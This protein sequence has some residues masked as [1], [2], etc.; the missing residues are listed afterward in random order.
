MKIVLDMQGAQ[1]QSRHRG[2]GRYSLELA[3]AFAALAGQRHDLQFAFNAQLDEAT[4]ALIAALQPQADRSHRLMIKSLP[5]VAAQGAENTARRQAAEQVMRLALDQQHADVVWYSSMIEGYVDDAVI[6]ELPV[7]RG[8]S[9][10]TLYDLIPLHDPDAY[11]GHP[12]VRAW[13]DAKVKAMAQCDLL[14]AI[15]DWV[16]DD[17]L[18]RLQLPAERVVTVG[19]GV[20]P[21]FARPADMRGL[22]ERTRQ[23]HGI[24]RP[25]VLY[26]GGFDPRKNVAGLIAAY[27]A[28]P[29]SLR[30][31]YQLVIVGRIGTE[32]MSLLS[33]AM[34]EA[35]LPASSVVFTGYVPDGALVNLYA[36]CELFVFPSSMEGFGLP[37]LEAMAC[38]APV[39]GSRTTSLPEVIGEPS[40]M[41]DPS[42]RDA[43]TRM[44]REVLEQPARAQALRAHGAR[45]ARK[46]SWPAVAERALLAIE[47]RASQPARPPAPAAPGKPLLY[48][49]HDTPLPAWLK[50]LEQHYRM[51]VT[52]L[53]TAMPEAGATLS[54]R[55]RTAD[56]ILYVGHAAGGSRLSAWMQVWPGALLAAA[57]SNAPPPPIDRITRSRS[58]YASHGYAALLGDVPPA[59]DS[60][61][62]DSGCL[63]TL[64]TDPAEPEPA[65]ACA[66]QLEAWYAASPLADQTRALDE[67]AQGVTA[68]L[69]EDD[70]ARVCDAI[71]ASMPPSGPR[72]W[73]VD[74]TQIA[75]HDIGTGVQRVVRS[76]LRQ[77]L[78]QPPR[79]VRIEP[80]ALVDGHY[81]YA[82][83]YALG[84]L[85]LEAGLLDDDFV[86][87][88]ANDTYVGLD[89][90]AETLAAGEP[91]LR[92][93]HRAGVDMHFVVHDLLPLTLP[94]AFHPF[95]RELF[96]GWLRRVCTLAD[97]LHCVSRATADELARWM[98]STDLP[99][100]F[101]QAPS[102]ASFHLG[103][104]PTTPRT[105]PAALPSPLAQAAAQRPTL[106]MVGTLEPRKAHEL[107]LDAVERLWT[108]QIDA[109]LVIVGH[110]GWLVEN[111][112]RRLEGHTERDRRLF[113][114][115]DAD[116]ATL[117]A[118]YAAATA[119]LAPSLGEGF[120]LPLI[121]AA[122][123]QLPVIARDLPV[124]REI[125]G[126]YPHYFR[127][128]DAD[129]LA[130]SLAQWLA[131]RPQPG[132][133]AP[134]PDWARSAAALAGAVGQVRQGEGVQTIV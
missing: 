69:D 107:A 55:L 130:Q 132:A 5:R 43:I 29:P 109:N 10:A 12:R 106:L 33:A 129:G 18:A 51:E 57:G 41:F 56:R 125:M 119:L 54:A 110:H 32:P 79:D 131:E 98:T 80:V 14:L 15:S 34:R 108:R 22:A 117:E 66:R 26:N 99:Y 75:R 8:L 104:E 82:R 72:R 127:A 70:L 7:R 126:D 53:P 101:G 2:I 122:H 89:W 65:A 49:L 93:W 3:K 95:A 111:L 27:G 25:Y 6:P 115:A 78:L 97:R 76:V 40:A 4:D 61:T 74:V 9:V 85:G 60:P 100:Q 13:Y 1:C 67:L 105:D 19:A 48:C 124:F 45:Q 38:G 121:E 88:R 123:H 52:A 37:P 86:S 50:D 114:L 58:A 94:D 68:S 47:A 113:W 92:E 16:R 103:V 90:S 17:A 120:G 21:R 46:F 73:L 81:R 36:C 96:A 128:T 116:D 23:A 84:L 102:I 35:R 77:W 133:P 28:L 112:I 20:D 83:H 30:E 64:V 39:I 42:D 118:I 31:Q 71:A 62:P 134:W 63:G 87:I 24:H 11:L 44:M 91:L 59:C